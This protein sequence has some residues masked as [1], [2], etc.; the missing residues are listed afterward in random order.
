MLLAYSI[1]RT[2]YSYIGNISIYEV[3]FTI[4][5]ESLSLAHALCHT[6]R[7]HPFERPWLDCKRSGLS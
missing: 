3:N 1:F 7:P 2:I 6:K 5:K 4:Y